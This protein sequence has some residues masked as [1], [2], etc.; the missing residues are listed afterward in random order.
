ME[1]QL[2]C[3]IRPPNDFDAVVRRSIVR[4]PV[5]KLEYLKGHQHLQHLHPFL[6]EGLYHRTQCSFI[7]FRMSTICPKW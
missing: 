6:L 7:I 1:F 4:F 2:Q 5:L 3:L